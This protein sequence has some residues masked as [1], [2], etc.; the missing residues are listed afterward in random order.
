MGVATEAGYS[1]T[2]GKHARLLH[3]GNRLQIKTITATEDS[4][5][6]ADLA[7][8]DLTRDRW[9]PFSNELLNPDA[10]DADDWTATNVTVASDGKT[11]A[12]TTDSGEHDL[13][14]AFTFT[15]E[16]HVVAFK[17]ERQTVPEVQLRANDGTSTFTCF[18]DLRDGTVGT[19]SGCTGRIV[20][21]GGGEF[22]LSIRFTPAAATGVVELLLS[23][24]TEA[25][26]YAG[27]TTNTIKL[28]RGYVHVSSASLRLDTFAAQE[29]SCFAIAAHN[30]GAAGARIAFEHDS[31][32]DDTWTEIGSIEPDDDSSIMFFF[33]PVT[34][35][36]WRITVD[37]GVLP[38]IGVVRVGAPLVFERPFYA[39]FSPAAMS[40]GTEVIG[41]MSRTGELLG[42]SIKRTILREE[43]P[44]QNL[45]Y[46]W[47][48][49][50][51]D[52]PRGVIQS[53][54][55]RA[56]FI[57]WRPSEA[58]DASYIMRASPGVPQASGSRD[59]WSFSMSA[60]VYAY[61]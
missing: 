46:D 38:E 57:A 17:V 8:N 19:A 41:N 12:E 36:R 4:G 53:V 59:L 5:S 43:Y 9:V 42:R 10:F 20:D 13:S 34:S 54:E 40:R 28:L 2:D 32:G 30:L 1:W 7:D 6:T 39:G 48:R 18:F 26:S 14:Q 51:L 58:D 31:N 52:G 50:N 44:W 47:V 56:A 27:A 21:L 45:S 22:L 35:D 37:R 49:A 25:V 29:A 61:E 16:E 55:A 23:D 60:E 11:I 24:G 3:E 33:D 15:A